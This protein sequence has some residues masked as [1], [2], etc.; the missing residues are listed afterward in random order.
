MYIN[1]A[2]RFTGWALVATS[3]HAAPLFA[4]ALPGG[5]EPG[6]LEQQFA[7]Q[8]MPRAVDEPLLPDSK[9]QLPPADAGKIRFTLTAIRLQGNTVFSEADLSGAFQAYLGQEVSLA[10]IYTIADAIA[11]HYRNAGYVL[12]RAT[13]PAQR[14]ANGV[15]LIA[16]TEGYIDAFEI[17]G[18]VRGNHDLL[19]AYVAKIIA[20]TPLN[21]RDLERYILLINDLPGIQAKAVLLPSA[22]NPGASRL[23]LQIGEDPWDATLMV[24]NRGT[25]FIGALQYRAMGGLNNFFGRS[26]RIGGQ[27]ITTQE[28]EELKFFELNYAEPIGSEGTVLGVSG[29]INWSNPGYTLEPFNVEGQNRSVTATVSHPWLRSRRKNLSFR[30]SFTYRNS[31]TDFGDAPFTEDRLRVLRLGSSADFAD[32]WRG[33]N[34]FDVE[35]S[36][37]LDILDATESGKITLPTTTRISGREDFTKITVSALRI[38]QISKPVQLVLGVNGQYALSQLLASEEFGYGGVP[39]GRAYDPSQLTGD[40]GLAGRAEGQYHVPY[41]DNYLR[42][43]DLYTFYDIGSVWHIDTSTRERRDSAASAGVGARFVIQQRL[44]GYIEVADPLTGNVPTRGDKG[45]EP[46]FFFSI[47]APL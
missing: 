22:E 25:K 38:Q 13:P 31:V 35:A 20:S 16:I 41:R 6:R 21:N 8:P 36:Q 7:P 17:E 33:V 14:V 24:E 42:S 43:L 2:F 47:A 19:D 9:K 29:N 18:E 5:A 3:L 15:V 40:H 26:E 12:T 46:R 32:R 45:D 28:T 10:T 44:L 1:R 34:L 23:V 39:F 27:A 4:Q 30:G 11:A 37:G